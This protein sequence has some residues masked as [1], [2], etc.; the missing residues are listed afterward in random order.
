MENHAFDDQVRH[1]L[2]HHQTNLDNAGN[3][4]DL[5]EQRLNQAQSPTAEEE[6]EEI[7]DSIIRAKINHRTPAYNPTHWTIMAAKLDEYFSVGAWIL[8]NK[9]LEFGLTLFFIF[10]F[11][12]VLQHPIKLPRF[13]QKNMAAAKT[14]AFKMQADN[15]AQASA[16]A[17]NIDDK[18]ISIIDSK[19]LQNARNRGIN[20][21]K[22][23]IF[24][25]QNNMNTPLTRI[26][27]SDE[28]V[29]FANE[30]PLNTNDAISSMAKE[31]INILSP[32]ETAIK[33]IT[34]NER[35]L[36]HSGMLAWKMKK[37]RYKRS[38]SLFATTERNDIA[39]PAVHQF[40]FDVPALQQRQYDYG[41]GGLISWQRKRY[42]FSTGLTYRQTTYSAANVRVL[43]SNTK[44][45]TEAFTVDLPAVKLNV[46]SI[47]LFINYDFIAQNRWSIGA[48][49]GF[50]A[51][52]ITQAR[53]DYSTQALGL[54]ARPTPIV[55]NEPIKK[56][57]KRVN[58][59][60]GIFVTK[61][62]YNNIFVS[63]HVGINGQYTIR[64]RWSIFTNM[65]YHHYL[66]GNGIGPT[67]DKINTW[68]LWSGI[69]KD[70]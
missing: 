33:E 22:K 49:I 67:N 55:G 41:V 36:H 12:N 29:V 35:L 66:S 51:N 38:L 61:T 7:F 50:S 13:Q 27:N 23:D 42:S 17:K 19:I 15:A 47:P 52:I 68:S 53:F 39:T 1:L 28:N 30:Q 25:T 24:D 5:M 56:P 37:H 16:I 18:N 10:T 63:S 69:K 54:V 14:D 21:A 43:K 64:P 20:D 58:Y 6:A 57:I 3:H 4:W 32:I 60:D 11:V 44:V 48:N 70:F 34:P 8:R 65:Q 46:A 31:K 40:Y 62:F 2:Q 59:T 45:S 26:E 9:I